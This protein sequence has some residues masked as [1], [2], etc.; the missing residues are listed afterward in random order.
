MRFA[1]L[2]DHP[3]GLD[4]AGALV[5]S[6]RHSLAACTAVLDED[7]R[8]RLG[9]PRLVLDVEEVLADPAIE[10]VIVAGAPSVRR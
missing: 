6:G 4:M 10:A 8:Q 7:I 2:G 9:Q 5:D 3:D 1:L